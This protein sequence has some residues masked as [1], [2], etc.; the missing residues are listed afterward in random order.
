MASRRHNLEERA[1]ERQRAF[2]L[3]ELSGA[4]LAEQLR[5]FPVGPIRIGGVNPINV[6][7]DRQ[8]GS[9]ERIGEQKRACV[10]AVRRNA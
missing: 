2:M 5:F 7:H 3:R 1:V 8:A 9:S 10:G 4:V 6:L